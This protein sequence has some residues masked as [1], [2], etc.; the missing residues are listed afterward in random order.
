MASED[1][2][3]GQGGTAERRARTAEQMRA[4]AAPVGADPDPTDPDALVAGI[5]QTREDLAE[6]LDAIVDKVSPKRVA[7]RTTKRVGDAAKEGVAD[8][9]DTVKQTAASAKEGAA[10][11]AATAKLSAKEGVSEAAE[12]VKHSAAAATET[13]KDVA[14]S[15]KGKLAPAPGSDS[16]GLR[17]GEPTA[18]ELSTLPT[19]DFAPYRPVPPPGTGPSRA[20]MLAGAAAAAAVAVVLLL[21][22]RRRR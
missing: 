2:T 22:R 16:A 3:T 12:S 5:E 11:A 4:P 13:V 21:V 19:S 9:A 17:G 6:T 14:A 15:V 7:K 1:R 8:A 18:A 10:D 20:P